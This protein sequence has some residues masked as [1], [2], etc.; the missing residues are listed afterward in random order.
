MDPTHQCAAGSLCNA[1]A[2]NYL[3]PDHCCCKCEKYAHSVFCLNEEEKNKLKQQ[4]PPVTDDGAAAAATATA[5]T[6]PIDLCNSDNDDDDNTVPV[7]ITADARSNPSPLT[8]NTGGTS[9]I[10]SVTTRTLNLRQADPASRKPTRICVIFI[11]QEKMWWTRCLTLQW[12]TFRQ[13]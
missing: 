3:G 2:D 7:T 13:I 9:S 11:R 6:N 10:S 8:T 4:V 1:P 12:D 5:G